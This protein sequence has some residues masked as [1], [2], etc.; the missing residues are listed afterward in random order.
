MFIFYILFSESTKQY[1]VGH[2]GNIDDRLYRHNQGRSKSTKSGIP[3]E[4]VYTENYKTK[5]EAYQREINIKK[6]KSIEQ[7]IK[8][9]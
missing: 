1:Y 3:W 7:L 5:S 6:Q 2:T 9:V 8:P 4:L